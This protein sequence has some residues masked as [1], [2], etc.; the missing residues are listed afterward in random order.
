MVDDLKDKIADVT[1]TFVWSFVLTIATAM[2]FIFLLLL[3]G[4]K[5][6]FLMSPG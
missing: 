3:G 1:G 4:K 2:I 6:Y 5:N